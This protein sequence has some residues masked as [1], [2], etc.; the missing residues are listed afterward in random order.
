MALVTVINGSPHGDGYTS[1]LVARVVAGIEGA[2]ASADVVPLRH[3]RIEP[4]VNT[5]GWPCWP[6]G[7]CT[8]VEDDTPLVKAR[9]E[10]G[11]GLVIACP[12]YWSSVNGLTINFLD[13]L[14]LAGFAGKPALAI[15]VA[16]GSGNGMVLALRALHSFF[17]WGWRPLAP[18]PVSRFNY[19]QARV[20]AE[21]RGREI[22]AAALA[23]PRSFASAA[24][25]WRWELALPFVDWRLL[26]EKLY[27]AGLVV[28]NAPPAPETA[29]EDWEAACYALAAARRLAAAGGLEAAAE[30]I[31]TAYE[32]GRAV[33][34]AAGAA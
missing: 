2:G 30:E 10:A 21:A 28:E 27:L 22:A 1:G 17:G 15:T 5:P 16:G 11:D 18:L 8:H 24:E 32:R 7:P 29:R 9:V 3:Y 31:A 33:W 4:C 14:R 13:K 6:D 23:G 20:E 34:R 26:E 19:E 12:V 25:Q